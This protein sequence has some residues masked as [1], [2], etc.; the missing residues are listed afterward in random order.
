MLSNVLRTGGSV[1][2]LLAFT[3][4]VFAQAAPPV[5]A[6]AGTTYRAKQVL[7]SKIMINNN[8]QVGTVD[9]IVFDS[10]GNLEYLIVAHEGK[11]TTVPWDAAKFN[12]KNQ[13]AT[14]NV[15]PQVWQTIP[16]YTPTTYPDFWA[17]AYRTQ[18]Y[19]YY[20]LTPRELRR[21][22]RLGRP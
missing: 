11:L 20:N 16:T 13:T 17:P 4:A 3:P 22:E 10:A 18:V 1:A 19:K 5:A 14:V 2:F 7:G 21:M 15:T 8:T 12:V 9:D 6:A